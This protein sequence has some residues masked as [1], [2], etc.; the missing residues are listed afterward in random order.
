MEEKEQVEYKN[1]YIAIFSTNYLFQGVNQ[2]LFA[3][4]IPIFLLTVVGVLDVTAIA[5]LG[6][7]IGLPWIF[8]IFFGIIGDK[9][10]SKKFGRRRPWI[11]AMTSLA[12]LMWI[13][14]GFPG[15]LTPENAF[16]MFFL[17]GFFIFFGV[18]F[19]DT[20]L[21]GLILDICPKEK[22][23]RTS[24]FCWGL[25]SVGAIAG[26]PLLAVLVVLGGMSVP[27]IFM[28]IGVLMIISSLLTIQIKEPKKYPEVKII[29]HLKAMF[30]NKKDI[31]TYAFALFVAILDMVVILFISIFI[32][33]E[34]NLIAAE[35][36]SLSLTST[37]PNIYLYQ[38]NLSMIISIGVVFGAII[39]GQ[40][41]D[42]MTRKL[43]VYLAMLISTVSLLLMLLPV[44]WPILLFFSTL[45]GVA[46]GWR[47]SS[48]AAVVTG[49]SKQHPEMDSTYYSVCNA[50]ANFGGIIGMI[51]TG[52]ILSATASYLLVFLFMAIISNLGLIGFLMLDPKDYEVKIIDKE[53]V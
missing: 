40:V 20:I 47:H 27:T 9:V 6:T 38:G 2:S 39:G 10:G 35:G 25:R 13:I 4:L 30:S 7:I 23:G 29:L 43:A 44:P 24:G 14:L 52:M 36:T 12:G 3:V 51:I 48:Y 34:M 41:A 5:F 18:A 31:K 45:V 37:D 21:D 11:I 19:S 53:D 8:K 16:G 50:F 22:L 28:I 1:Y 49:M 15:F 42:R 26:G 17:F 33:I 32:L 46:I